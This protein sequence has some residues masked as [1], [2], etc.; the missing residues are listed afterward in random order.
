MKYKE[1]WKT[2]PE[3][4]GHHEVSNL[5]RVRS[6]DRSVLNRGGAWALKGHTMKQRCHPRTG[7]MMINVRR[8]G[9][10]MLVHRLVAKAFCPNPEN[11]PTVNHINGIK[12]DNRA[13]NLE[14][15]TYHENNQHAYDAGLKARFHAG[16]YLQGSN[17]TVGVARRR[18]SVNK[19]LALCLDARAS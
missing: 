9:K 19:E 5:G 14:W 4:E 7:Y 13:I 1:I 8:I 10:T 3:L 2:I 16:Q 6:L 11:K 12:S 15:A 17:G 18:I